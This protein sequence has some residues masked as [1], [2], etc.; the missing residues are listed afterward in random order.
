VTA[1]GTGG[2]SGSPTASVRVTVSRRQA[3]ATLMHGRRQARP[4]TES[5]ITTTPDR[6]ASMPLF[7]YWQSS[8]WL[9]AQGYAQRSWHDGRNHVTLTDAGVDLAEQEGL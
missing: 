2:P 3:L 1:A 9:E 4:V 6:W 7:V 5:N 8:Q